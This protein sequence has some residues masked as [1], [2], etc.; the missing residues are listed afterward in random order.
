MRPFAVLVATAALLAACSSASAPAH[1][2]VVLGEPP[3]TV[4]AGADGS[5]VLAGAAGA[6]LSFPPD[7]WQL[8]LIDGGLATGASYDPY[9]LAF[10]PGGGT[11]DPPPDLSWHAVASA[12]IASSDAASVVVHL[13][14]DEGTAATLAVQAD[15][16]GRFSASLVPSAPAS[17][18]IAYLR[19]RPRADATE[20]FYGLGE[21]EDSVDSR[22]KLR[23]MQM[24]A[25]GTTES[26]DNEAHV[27]VPLV[28]GTRGWGLFVESKRVGLFDVARSDPTL[29]E[30]TYGTA[31]QSGDGL[32][33]HLFGADHPLDVTRLY[34]DVTG[35]P[36]LPAQWALG[37]WMWRDE[38][39]DQAQVL[40]DMQT[41]RWLDLAASGMWFDRPYAT[42]VNT[43]DF[44]AKKFSDPG[45]MLAAIHDAGFRIAAW[46]TPYEEPTAQPMRDEVTQ[47]GYFPPAPGLSLNG[48]SEPID[49]TNPA[50]YAFWQDLVGRYTHA[51]I[52]G[53]K[54][55][56]GEDV[57]P[58]LLKGRSV[59]GFADGSDERTMHYGYT[60]LYHRA[61]AEMLPPSGGYLLCRAGR[62]GDQRNVSVVW[63]GDMDATMTR[64]GETFTDRG[65]GSPVVG[66]GGLPA[67][68]VMGLTLGPSGFPFFAADT[69]GY[70]HSPAD[71]E[72][73]VR[74][75]EQTALST[76]MNVGDASSEMPWEFN[77]QN[78][79]DQ[80]SLDLYR[81]YVRLHVRLFPYEW[82]YAQ[83]IA[84]DGRPITRSL[85]LAYP[86]LGV[87]P[88]DIY[89]FGDDLLVAP[90][91][92]HGATTRD[93][94]LPAGTW[95]DWWDGTAYAGPQTVTM[96]APLGKLPL[97]V[98]A[99]GVVP[100]LRP[101]IDTMSPTA[102]APAAVDSFATD[103]GALF[104]R[105]AP[106]AGATSSFVVYDGAKVDASWSSDG[107]TFAVGD[108]AVFHQGATLEAIA[109][110][111]PQAVTLDGAPLAQVADTTALAS[112]TQG[113]TWEAATG[114]TLWIKVPGGQRSVVVR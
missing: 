14:F 87:H 58:A 89:L 42:A 16:P 91:V 61:Y 48:W 82:T 105:L 96:Q 107:A 85:G 46:S 44:S 66:V 4:T 3:Y 1:P 64:H 53:F 77:A 111:R 76:V 65:S 74:W 13:V 59:W 83:R 95:L 54:L 27:P 110:A 60:L 32:R 26:P 93:V 29:V 9:W 40:S 22:G 2:P 20:G 112:A 101:T 63:P 113:W 5:L 51:G 75:F 69:G 57:V 35:Y 55:D 6:L 79:W 99:G 70:R 90:V 41:I 7:A 88:D 21:H 98:R 102:M 104:V 100:L 103:P 39:T 33:F 78:G 11:P 24:E 68:V 94:V 10:A 34:Y 109:T 84:E 56:Y 12:S 49:F 80:E 45:S 67:T 30:I 28:I 17:G 18:A 72:T 71:K 31:E 15:A 81:Q 19:L 50:A 8:G 25:D 23:P 37:P 52:E 92:T 106:G 97:L 38:N 73:F 114:G 108:G 47:K 43:F 36:L 62:W 86:E